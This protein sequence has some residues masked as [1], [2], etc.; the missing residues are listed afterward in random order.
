MDRLNEDQVCLINLLFIICFIE[1]Q[2]SITVVLPNFVY[3][4]QQYQTLI[5]HPL[6]DPVHEMA[7]ILLVVQCF[8][9]A[10]FLRSSC[11]FFR[12][13]CLSIISAYEGVA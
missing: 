1:L 13:L 6:F 4:K 3:L 8:C 11:K 12:H 10:V 2:K 9:R 5:F 7:F